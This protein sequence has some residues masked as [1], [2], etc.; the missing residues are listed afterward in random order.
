VNNTLLDLN[1]HLFAQMDRLSGQDLKGEKLKSEIDRSNA[2]AKVAAQ[3]I[4][5]GNLA[6]K[7]KMM[8]NENR[9]IGDK[10]MPPML[11]MT[12]KER[13]KSKK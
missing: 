10:N 2:M 6:L 4:S 7:I 3:I 11:D 5:N 12:D 9:I 13:P 1:N 8:Q